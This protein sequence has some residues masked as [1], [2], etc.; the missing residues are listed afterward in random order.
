MCY[1]A[2]YVFKW[3]EFICFFGEYNQ[4]TQTIRSTGIIFFMCNFFKRN[5]TIKKDVSL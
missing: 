1:Y 2:R 4:K 3:L 5:G